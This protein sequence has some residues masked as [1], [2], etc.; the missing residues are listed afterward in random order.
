MTSIT[1]DLHVFDCGD[2]LGQ[3]VHVAPGHYQAVDLSGR[4]VGSIRS[5]SM[6]HEVILPP[7]KT[8]PRQARYFTDAARRAFGRA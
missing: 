7:P 8:K 2:Y 3:L 4:T 1:P 6:G 5:H